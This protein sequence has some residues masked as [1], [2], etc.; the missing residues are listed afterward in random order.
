MQK[1]NGGFRLSQSGRRP[2]LARLARAALLSAI[3]LAGGSTSLKAQDLRVLPVDEAAEDPGL[4]AFRAQVQ[5]AVAERDTAALLAIVDPDIKLSFGDDYGVARFREMLA[6]PEAGTWAELGTVLALG[7]RFYDDSTFAAPYTF[8]DAP[9]KVDPFEALIAIG[10]SVPVH[11]GPSDDAEMVATLSFD[12][13]R[14]EWEGR[15]PLP[16]GWTAVRLADGTLA[17]VRSR[18]VR[19]PIDH[20]AIFSRQGGRWWMTIF[21]AGD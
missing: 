9:D 1:S 19:S 16:D 13:V 14:R 21:I 10:D 3:V 6:D 11:A 8:T 7:G 17:Y 18:W 4:F 5:R 2:R 15:D 12:V 20:R